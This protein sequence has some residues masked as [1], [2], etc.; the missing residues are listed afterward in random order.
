M[1]ESDLLSSLESLK[2]PAFGRSLKD[3]Q[4]LAGA[5]ESD[6]RWTVQIQLPTHAYLLKDELTALIKSTIAESSRS[7]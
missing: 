5:T 4:M 2:D 6:G 1:N 7:G 3:L